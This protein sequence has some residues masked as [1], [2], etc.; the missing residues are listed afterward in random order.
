VVLADLDLLDVSNVWLI[1]DTH[2]GHKNIINFTTRSGEKMRPWD[3]IEEMDEAMIEN[4]N[5]VVS[6][7]DK[8]Y[9]LGDV[10]MNSKSL[11]LLERLKGKKV[12]IKGNHDTQ[13][14]KFYLPHFYDIRGSH[15]LANLLL[16]HI[17]VNKDQSAR[18]FGNV[19]GHLHSEVI[20]DPW[21]MNVSVEQTNYT[22]I[23]FDEVL[24]TYRSNG[25]IA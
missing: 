15:E 6:V 20:D 13:K 4:W 25:F 19:H 21:Y 17:P 7:G 12:L 3:S 23:S 24:A 10:T 2:F 14:L 5:R 16:T 18:Y 1:S 22:P 11:D 9:H 8:V